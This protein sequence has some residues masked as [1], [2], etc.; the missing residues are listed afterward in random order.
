MLRSLTKKTLQDAFL[1]G[2]TSLI[3]KI[4]PAKCPVSI[5][6]F[7]YQAVHLCAIYGYLDLLKY[8][9]LH[10]ADL[11]IKEMTNYTPLML[12][13]THKKIDI[14][15]YLLNNENVDLDV[16]VDNR[17]YDIFRLMLESEEKAIQSLARD[18][19]GA[20]KERFILCVERNQELKSLGENLLRLVCQY[21]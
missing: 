9:E 2:N 20:R 18:Y 7:S 21:V 15:E 14:V 1:H 6:I 10:G 16:C 13:I 5:D 12:A 8:L 4:I 3:Q 19:A 17:G 11:N